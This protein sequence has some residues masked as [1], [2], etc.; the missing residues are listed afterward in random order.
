M[1]ISENDQISACLEQLGAN[2][3]RLLI[4]SGSLSTGWNVRATEWLAIKDREERLNA[5]YQ[6]E[7]TKIARAA[8]DAA[9]QAAAAA[10]RASIAAEKLT[11]AAKR[12]KTRA[13]VALLV[14]IACM[15]ATIASMTNVHLDVIQTVLRFNSAE[16]ATANS[17]QLEKP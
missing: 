13:T 5:S 9:K 15:I 8:S 17:D 10:E 11:I 16:T 2:Q 1:P 14:A 7:Q 3:V 12:A 6:G 4:S